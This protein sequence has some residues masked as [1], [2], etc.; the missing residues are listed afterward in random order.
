MAAVS[1]VNRV[2]SF[3][4]LESQPDFKELKKDIKGLSP[5]FTKEYEAQKKELKERIKTQKQQQASPTATA[6]G[7]SRDEL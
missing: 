5:R 7:E 2:M 4:G 6:T 1:L 3:M